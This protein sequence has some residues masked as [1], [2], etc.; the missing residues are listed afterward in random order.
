MSGNKCIGFTCGYLV[1]TDSKSDIWLVNPF[2]RHELK[3]PTSPKLWSHVIL[4]SLVISCE[5]L[6]GI[7]VQ[8]E[9]SSSTNL[10]GT[11]LISRAW[12]PGKK[13]QGAQYVIS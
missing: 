9:G 12:L 6:G 4:T 5:F 3:F 13:D 10:F 2:T 7:Q 11:S 8:D 1:L